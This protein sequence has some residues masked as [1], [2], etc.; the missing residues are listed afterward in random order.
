MVRI[1]EL[2]ASMQWDLPVA[3]G[4]HRSRVR[5]CS[6]TGCLAAKGQATHGT[7][8]RNCI[9]ACG[10]PDGSIILEPPPEVKLGFLTAAVPRG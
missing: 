2:G 3:V 4:R 1:T 8:K 5:R 10:L 9:R 6:P 7:H